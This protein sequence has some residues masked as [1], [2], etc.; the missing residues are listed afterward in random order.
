[1]AHSRKKTDE[2]D[3]RGATGGEGNLTLGF[4]RRQGFSVFMEMP[5]L[6]KNISVLVKLEC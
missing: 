4:K 3:L 2:D 1:M 6:D 5:P